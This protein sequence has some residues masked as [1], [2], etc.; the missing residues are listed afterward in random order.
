M[1][2]AHSGTDNTGSHQASGGVAQELTLQARM[3]MQYRWR[4]FSMNMQL[5]ISGYWDNDEAFQE[6]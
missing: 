4:T 5:L 6:L 1:D 3:S 2:L